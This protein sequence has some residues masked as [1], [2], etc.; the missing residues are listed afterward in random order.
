MCVCVSVCVSACLRV[1]V[2]LRESVWS[3]CVRHVCVCVIDRSLKR[4]VR[5]AT[6]G[7]SKRKKDGHNY[8]QCTSCLHF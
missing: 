6:E 8:S 4:D 5:V 2:C 3:V 1:C 7:V